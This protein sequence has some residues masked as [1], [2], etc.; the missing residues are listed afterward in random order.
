MGLS[1][2]EYAG[3]VAEYD[4]WT[5]PRKRRPVVRIAVERGK[6]EEH[7]FWVARVGW[8]DGREGPKACAGEERG[9]E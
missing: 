3:A 7:P 4:R 8:Q 2:Q 1:R 5:A 6:V 9:A